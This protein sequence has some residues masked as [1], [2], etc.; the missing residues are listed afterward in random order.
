M[1]KHA[2]LAVDH[3][4]RRLVYVDEFRPERG[5]SVPVPENPRDLRR[6]GRDRVLLSHE[7]GLAEF[8]LK[9]GKRTWML[10]AF[11]GI[12]T[13]FA[14]GPRGFLLGGNAPE[15]IVLY[16]LNP[17]GE[18]VRRLPVPEKRRLHIM[19]RLRDGNVLFPHNEPAR[20]SEVTP[21]GKIVRE[22]DVPG[23][24]DMVRVLATG[25]ILVATGDACEIVEFDPSGAVV[26]RAGGREAHP[27]LGLHWF[28]G[29]D[30]LDNG[31]RV[32]SNWLG[33]GRA[34]DGPC[35]VEFD[36]SGRVVWTWGDKDRV[37]NASNIL[38]LE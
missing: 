7:R 37:T 34:V 10:D 22:L 25:H 38:V 4:G 5:W 1:V 21:E 14:T 20:V 36:R 24:A 17:E 31:N 33:D 8:E 30:L 29:F 11:S 3:E 23:S 12:Q 26:R 6:V 16:E 18:E 35:F 19:Q 15:G 27:T 13:G 28:C 2:F 9:T 32:V